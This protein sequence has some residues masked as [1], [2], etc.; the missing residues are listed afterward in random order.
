MFLV[1]YCFETSSVNL[2]KMLLE[3]ES[4]AHYAHK[5]N[6]LDRVYCNVD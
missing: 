6:V 5:I 1:V 3:I 4:R 2:N